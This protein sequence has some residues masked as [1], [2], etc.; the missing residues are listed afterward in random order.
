MTK[1]ALMDALQAFN[2]DDHLTIGEMATPYVPKIRAVCGKGMKH[3]PYYCRR[4]PGLAR[5]CRRPALVQCV[6]RAGG[7]S[8]PRDAAGYGRC[9]DH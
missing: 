9:W 3:M 6:P 5:R 2:D 1:K 8:P 7:R 4:A